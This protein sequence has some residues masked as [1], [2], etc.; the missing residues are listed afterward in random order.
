AGCRAHG[1][2]LGHHLGGDPRYA[3]GVLVR[4]Q[5]TTL[6]AFNGIAPRA[7]PARGG[8]GKGLSA[9]A[10]KRAVAGGCRAAWRFARRH[11]RAGW[12]FLRALTGE[13]AYERYLAHWQACHSGEAPL[14]RGTFFRRELQRRWEG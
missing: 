10:W 7:E 14:D 3:A 4:P 13:D 2:L 6:P 9:S 5:R 12:N 1:A 8:L 11:A